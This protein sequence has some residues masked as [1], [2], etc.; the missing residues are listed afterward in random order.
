MLLKLSQS[1]TG[2]QPCTAP[3]QTVGHFSMGRT[4]ARRGEEWAHLMDLKASTGWPTMC[5]SASTLC[6]GAERRASLGLAK[7][8]WIGF[9][10]GLEGGS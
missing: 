10:S 3:P 2:G 9:R 5:P 7:A 4:L 6:P 8:C 1:A